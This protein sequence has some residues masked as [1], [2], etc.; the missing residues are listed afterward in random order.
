MI[1]M[2][3]SFSTE[4]RLADR[5]R[6]RPIRRQ[7]ERH[8]QLLGLSMGTFTY[9]LTSE[10]SAK[11]QTG[12]GRHHVSTKL[13]RHRPSATQ[14]ID[15][16]SRLFRSIANRQDACSTF[17]RSPATLRRYPSLPTASR[18]DNFCELIGQS[19]SNPWALFVKIVHFLWVLGK[20]VESVLVDLRVS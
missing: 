19:L 7:F 3:L 2:M 9:N 15:Q 17:Q 20:V 18:I 6:N 13:R 12:G 1:R 16:P 11:A 14:I 4:S 5:L 8:V 10:A